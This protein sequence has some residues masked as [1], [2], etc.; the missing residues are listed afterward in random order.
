MEITVPGSKSITNR[1][2]LLAAL[3]K[4]VT[5]LTG[6]LDSDDTRACLQALASLGVQYSGSLASGALTIE[7]V[8]GVF[9]VKS[10]SIDCQASG[11]VTRFLLPLLA[12]QPSGR[13]QVYA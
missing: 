11:T 7:G 10:A 2:L 3:A 9:P 8:Q 6:V 4:G 12:A 5:H 1:A 13:Y